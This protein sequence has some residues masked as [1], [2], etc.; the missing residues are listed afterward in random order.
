MIRQLDILVAEGKIFIMGDDMPDLEEL[1]ELIGE[2]PPAE[3]EE[4]IAN[5]RICG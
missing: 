2:A 4:I 3:V 5:N 1:E